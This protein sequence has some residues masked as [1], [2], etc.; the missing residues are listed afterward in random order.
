MSDLGI[1][2]IGG[3]VG[4]VATAV[5]T[6]FGRARAAWSQMALHDLEAAERNAQLMV[7]VDDRT[8]QL[9]ID[10]TN[11]TADCAGRELLRSGIHGGNLKLAKEQALHEYRDEEWRA[12]LDLFRLRARGAA[13]TRCGVGSD[14]DPPH[15]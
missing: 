4:S 13:G 9:L 5:L 10:M 1:A 14:V 6:Q 12:R 15:P 7:W 8:R 11:I 2:L 3:A